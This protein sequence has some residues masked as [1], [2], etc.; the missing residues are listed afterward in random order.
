LPSDHAWEPYPAFYELDEWSLDWSPVHGLRVEAHRIVHV[1][2]SSETKVG[3][4]RIWDTFYQRL[5]S[6][7]GTVRDTAGQ[8]LYSVGLDEVRSMA[9][10]SEFRLYS[11]DVIRAV[12]LVAPQPPYIVEARWTVEI[13]N[14]FFW[15]D[16]DLGDRLPRR[17]AVYRIAVP[18]RNEVRHRQVVSSLIKTV[19]RKPRREVV[20]WELRDWVPD[21]TWPL[22]KHRAVPLL[23]VAPREF[24]VGRRKGRTDSW[25]ALGQ[26]YRELTSKQIGLTDEQN[27][28]VDEHLRD[29]VGPRAQAASLKDWVSDHWRYVAIEVGLGG[30]KPHASKEVFDNRYGDCKDVVFL[31]VSMMRHRGLQAFPALIRARNP[32]PVDASFPKDWFDHVVGMAVIDGDTLWADPSDHR[33]RLGTLPRSCEARW[34]LVVGELDAEGNLEFRARVSSR[35]HYAQLLPHSGSTSLVSPI[36]AILGVAAPAIEGE[37][38]GVEVVSSDEVTTRVHGRIDGWAVGGPTRMVVRPR[39]AG[40]MAVDTLAGRPTPSRVDFPQLAFD[41]LV[42]RF[43]EGW[44]PE[45]WPAAGFQSGTAGEFGEARFFEDGRLVLVRHVRWEECGRSKSGQR[46]AA[47]LRTAYSEAENAEWIFRL[48]SA[49]DDTDSL[50]RTQESL[51]S[52]MRNGLPPPDTVR[53]GSDGG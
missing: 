45:L 27:S 50:D 38:D 12:D 44:E 16:W 26:W 24:R 40:W 52:A 29:I 42:I 18:P 46:G 7:D 30:W 6:F 48:I 36:A 51:D 25:E 49:A 33:Y 15:P 32:L 4:I 19:E 14:P 35:G 8:V 1:N 13:D 37:L 28:R 9:P 11:G 39:L 43:P 3:Q 10:F 53:S 2:H 17:R 5:K 20:T 41:T 22:E 47:L 34:A 23:H 21:E 31:W